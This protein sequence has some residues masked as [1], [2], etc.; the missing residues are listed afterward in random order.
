MR[1]LLF[2]FAGADC[3]AQ[4]L[5]FGVDF[6]RNRHAYV[7]CDNEK[8]AEPAGSLSRTSFFDEV[9]EQTVFYDAKCGIPLFTLGSRSLAEFRKESISHGW[10]SFRDLEVVELGKNVIERENGEIVS[11]CGT[12]LGHNL[13]DTKGNRYCI[14]LL[15]VAG[16]PTEAEL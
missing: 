5:R 12:H 2:S 7:C 6:L 15:C 11:S 1:F 16:S 13:P 14:N 10:P 4:S 8:W 9:Q 3:L